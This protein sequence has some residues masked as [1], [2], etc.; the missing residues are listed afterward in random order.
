MVLDWYM[1]CGCNITRCHCLVVSNFNR[2]K[3]GT[4]T[5]CSLPLPHISRIWNSYFSWTHFIKLW[6][7]S[8]LPC[9][10]FIINRWIDNI[11]MLIYISI[12]ILFWNGS[13]NLVTKK[14]IFIKNLL[15]F[16]SLGSLFFVIDG[17]LNCDNISKKLW[18]AIMR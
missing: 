12:E 7:R 2:C 14:L 5:T 6:I 9:S 10:F 11:S 18:E 13:I 4:F 15:E 3:F 8:N 16:E 1:E 17:I